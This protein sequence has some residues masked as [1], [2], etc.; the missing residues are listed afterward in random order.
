MAESFGD[1]QTPEDLGHKRAPKPTEKALQEKLH[2]LIGTRKGKFSHLTIK[3]KEIDE[4]MSNNEDVYRVQDLLQSDVCNLHK[5]LV[6]LNDS[7]IPLM[8]EE[9]RKVDQEWF[10]NKIMSV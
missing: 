2:R 5:E 1:E 4:L 9:E 7:I 6:E 8:N 10:N 3:M